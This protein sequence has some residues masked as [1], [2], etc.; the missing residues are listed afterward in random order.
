MMI[1]GL[2]KKDYSIIIFQKADLSLHKYKLLSA[3]IT[4][5]GLPR[6]TARPRPEPRPG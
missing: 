4:K 5:S 6:I 2:S 1:G 3:N